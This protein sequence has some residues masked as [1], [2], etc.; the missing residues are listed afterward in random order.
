MAEIGVEET[1]TPTPSVIEGNIK[2]YV[3]DNNRRF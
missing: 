3:D 1:M 2:L